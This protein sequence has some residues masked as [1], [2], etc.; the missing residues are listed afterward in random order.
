M[1]GN[2]D[3]ERR[4]EL[5]PLRAAILTGERVIV[6]DPTAVQSLSALEPDGR[7]IVLVVGPEGGIS[8]A[9]LSRLTA[10]GASAWKLGGPVL[11]TSTAGPAAIAVLNS[12]LGR[13]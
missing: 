5:D 7:G 9:E 10:A 6:L 2:G 4:E 12:R 1:A 3:G 13:W 8:Q 11:R